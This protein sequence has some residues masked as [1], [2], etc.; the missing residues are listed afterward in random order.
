MGHWGK[1]KH[2]IRSNLYN[3]FWFIYVYIS[4]RTKKKSIKRGRR[5]F[6]TGPNVKV[7]FIL[8]LNY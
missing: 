8:S 5:I 7:N 2:F 6:V 4:L 3:E 1:E